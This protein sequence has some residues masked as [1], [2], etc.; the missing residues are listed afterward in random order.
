[1]TMPR[2]MTVMEFLMAETRTMLHQEIV[3]EENILITEE[4]NEVLIMEIREVFAMV[5]DPEG[6]EVFV[7]APDQKETEASGKNNK[8]ISMLRNEFNYKINI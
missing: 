5:L 6:I 2:I 3:P 4:E 8:Y 7:M 1:M